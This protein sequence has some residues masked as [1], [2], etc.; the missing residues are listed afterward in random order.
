MAI[1]FI[2]ILLYTVYV[3]RKQTQTRENNMTHLKF[4]VKM[5]FSENSSERR[6][7]RG[8]PLE[9][10]VFFSSIIMITLTGASVMSL[11]HIIH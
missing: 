2:R 7:V 4:T 10:I 11:I 9:A 1:A 3:L 8:T 5:M 6:I